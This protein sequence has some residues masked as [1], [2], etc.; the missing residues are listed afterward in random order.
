MRC[1]STK[2]EKQ[3]ECGL[4]CYNS[5]GT[6][7]VEDFSSYGSGS[8]SSEGITENWWC[9]SLGNYKMFTP[10]KLSKEEFTTLHCNACG[11]QQICKGIESEWFNNCKFKDHYGVPVLTAVAKI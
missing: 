8:I 10:I 1:C 11:A 7:Q 4:H 9:G 6:H 2:C 3:S 5:F